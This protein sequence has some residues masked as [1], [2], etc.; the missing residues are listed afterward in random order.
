MRKTP[1]PPAL[2]VGSLV[3]AL[4]TD[5]R[6]YRAQVTNCVTP[7]IIIRHTD[8]DGKTVI[9]PPGSTRLFLV[10][11]LASVRRDENNVPV[12]RLS[13]GWPE[14]QRHAA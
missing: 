7:H 3:T 9:D 4:Y 12:A 10:G 8:G 5:G 11:D 13:P 2:E 6:S 1:A 14:E